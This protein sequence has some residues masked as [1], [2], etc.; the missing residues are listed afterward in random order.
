MERL[1]IR[2][3]TNFSI[4]MALNSG[5]VQYCNFYKIANVGKLMVVYYRVFTGGSCQADYSYLN[6]SS[7]WART[8][9]PLIKNKFIL[10]GKD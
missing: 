5:N 2:I 6:C 8:V 9:H 4:D 3:I 7:E 10:S 1:N